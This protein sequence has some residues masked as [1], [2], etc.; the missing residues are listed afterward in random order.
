MAKRGNKKGGKREKRGRE[1]RKREEDGFKG[2][3]ERGY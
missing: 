2:V 3:E 1:K